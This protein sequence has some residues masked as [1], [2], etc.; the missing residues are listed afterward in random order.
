[1]S[2]LGGDCI[3]L[4]DP[5]TFDGQSDKHDFEWIPFCLDESLL[6]REDVIF[7]DDFNQHK[8]LWRHAILCIPKHCQFEVFLK[9]S[10]YLNIV[11]LKYS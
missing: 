10:E 5:C 7:D 11:N 8:W 4:Q 6:N 3:R 1:M 9:Y 2:F